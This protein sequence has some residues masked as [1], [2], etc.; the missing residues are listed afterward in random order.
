MTDARM[1]IMFRSL[2]LTPVSDMNNFLKNKQ[3]TK[4]AKKWNFMEE[5]I[6]KDGIVKEG[7][8]LKWTIF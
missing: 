6:R 2:K 8:V 3:W 5:R 7:N 4:D 1:S